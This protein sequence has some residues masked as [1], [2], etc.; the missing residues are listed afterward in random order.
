MK[1]L[2]PIF[3]RVLSLQFA[4]T[5]VILPNFALAKKKGNHHLKK[6]VTEAKVLV[7]KKWPHFSKYILTPTEFK[8]MNFRQQRA[9]LVGINNLFFLL[10][11]MENKRYDDP[12]LNAFYLQKVLSHLISKAQAKED[13]ANFSSNSPIPPAESLS[14]QDLRMD[15]PGTMASPPA[16]GLQSLPASAI[17]EENAAAEILDL[18]NGLAT[19]D[20]PPQKSGAAAE[21]SDVSKGLATVDPGAENVP[22]N[23]AVDPLAITVPENQTDLSKAHCLYGGHLSHYNVARGKCKVPKNGNKVAECPHLESFQDPF[24]CNDF[25]TNFVICTEKY[26]LDGNTVAGSLS[27]RCFK[28]LYKAFYQK[29]NLESEDPKKSQPLRYNQEQADLLKKYLDQVSD[30]IA[31]LCGQPENTRHYRYYIK[32]CEILQH[33]ETFLANN[34]QKLENPTHSHKVSEPKSSSSEETVQ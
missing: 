15:A 10:E 16:T 34:A 27:Q 25:G 4:L 29:N 17:A 23:S 21:I 33:L 1:K 31:N 8:K 13:S 12:K 11:R 22:G 26:P 24:R 19:V 2:F 30:Q 32:E 3:K 6:S 7:S 9:Y 5:F 18:T 20:L 14:D 28:V